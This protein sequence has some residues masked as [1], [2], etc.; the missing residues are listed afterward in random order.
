MKSD[1][2]P[3]TWFNPTKGELKAAGIVAP[4]AFDLDGVLSETGGILREGIQ[5]H[6]GI[7]DIRVCDDGYQ[8]FQYAVPGVGQREMFDLVNKIIA[9]ESMGALP[10]PFMQDCMRYFYDVTDEPVTIVT[11]RVQENMDVTYK[12][13]WANMPMPVP[14][15]LIMVNGMQKEV[16]L[17]RIKTDIFVDDRYKTVRN[18][19]DY[20]AMPVLYERPWN[21]NRPVKAGAFSIRD[22]RE[23]IP[24]FNMALQLRPMRWPGNIPYPNRMGRG[25]IEYA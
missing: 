10:T 2:Y 19:E 21:Q 11:A 24:V 5:S 12:W 8:T 15:N 20:I 25:D 1:I 22:L 16:V 13:L 18:L 3:Y 23:M 6:Y 7:D 9:E 14:Y 4:I 17:N